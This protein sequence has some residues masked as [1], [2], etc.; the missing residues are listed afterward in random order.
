MSWTVKTSEDVTDDKENRLNK[1][2]AA[3]DDGK[4]VEVTPGTLGFL[5]GEGSVAIA[6]APED[7]NIP[8]M[9]FRIDY[10]SFVDSASWA[11]DQLLDLRMKRASDDEIM[12][13]YIMSVIDGTPIPPQH[14]DQI[15]DVLERKAREGAMRMAKEDPDRLN[16]IEERYRPLFANT[17]FAERFNNIM[18]DVKAQ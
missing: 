6:V 14:Q 8:C 2:L 1:W 18:A 4:S 15:D 7:E 17:P 13:M 16:E 9:A 10:E 5:I 11:I 3:S 12:N